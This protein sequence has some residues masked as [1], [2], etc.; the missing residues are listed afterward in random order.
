MLITVGGE[1]EAVPKLPPE[2]ASKKD[3]IEALVKKDRMVGN[4]CELAKRLQ[5]LHGGKGYEVA[6]CAVFPHQSHGISYVPA[7][8]R[9]IS[10]AY[11]E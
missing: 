3:E 1:E 8:G 11:P 10:F 2:L 6:D 4:A 7:I 5:A 9:A